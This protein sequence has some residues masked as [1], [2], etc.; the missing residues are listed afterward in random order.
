V[1]QIRERALTLASPAD[2][3]RNGKVRKD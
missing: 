3:K 2:A 1:P